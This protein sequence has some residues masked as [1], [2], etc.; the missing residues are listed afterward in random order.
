MIRRIAAVTLVLSIFQVVCLT[1]SASAEVPQLLNYQ[2]R[3]TDPDGKPVN[4]SKEMVF[5]FYDEATDGNLLSDFSE[6]LALQPTA[7]CRSPFLRE[8]LFI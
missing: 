3:L 8:P 4:G 7:V 6:M 2:G 1:D 5:E